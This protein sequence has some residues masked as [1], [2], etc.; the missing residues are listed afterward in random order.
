MNRNYQTI[1]SLLQKS[2]RDIEIQSMDFGFE[3]LMLIAHDLCK[4]DRV[5]TLVVGNNI[6][7]MQLD[8]LIQASEDRLNIKFP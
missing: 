6:S 2:R 8:L 7:C 4:Y 1:T 5:I 3:T